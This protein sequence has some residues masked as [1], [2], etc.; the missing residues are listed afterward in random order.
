M[1]LASGRTQSA[2]AAAQ[3]PAPGKQRRRHAAAE[4]GAGR[5]RLELRLCLL[6]QTENG[7]RLKWLTICDEFSR[8]LIALE[9]ERQM[10]SRDVIGILEAA[11]EARGGPPEFIRSDNGPEFIARAVRGWIEQRGFKTLYI[12]PGH[13]AE[14]LQQKPQRPVLQWVPRRRGYQMPS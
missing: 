9:V 1:A 12:K 4:R 7:R 13:P 2:A 14:H 10:E 11:V 3:T 8:E 6:D 5:S